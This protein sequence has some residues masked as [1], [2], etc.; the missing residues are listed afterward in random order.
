[1]HQQL[2][3]TVLHVTHNFEEAMALADR[4]GVIGQGQLQQVGT[5]EEVFRR[6]QSEFVARFVG[7]RN[8]FQGRVE[9]L[10]DGIRCVRLDGVRVVVTH[11]TGNVRLMVR[12]E[13]ILLSH[14]PLASSAR[15]VFR[16]RVVAAT[17]SGPVLLVTVDVPPRFTAL[18]TRRS[19]DDLGL[20]EG[21]EVYLTFKASAVH[22]F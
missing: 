10:P 7:G 20:A 1:L 2:R 22:V 18:I 17:D 13:D 3:P 21:K 8:L 12:P 9:T 4:I 19:W 14:Q 16:G 11:G 5:P 6:P 15:N